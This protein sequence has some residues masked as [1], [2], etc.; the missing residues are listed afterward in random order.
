[1]TNKTN[2]DFLWVNISELPYFRGLLRAVEARFYQDIELQHPIF[3]LGCGDGQF[4]QTTFDH[5]I[6][7]GLDPWTGPIKK[8]IKTGAYQMVL[9]G[10]GA[11]IP[12]PDQSFNSAISNSV[13]EHIPELD[14]VLKEV[15]RIL[16]PGSLFVFCVPNHQFLGTLSIS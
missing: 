13:L 15:H 14:P 6:D 2:K 16:K 12:F 8:A 1:M 9:Q 7:V 5:T 4:A 10:S 3:D 11:D